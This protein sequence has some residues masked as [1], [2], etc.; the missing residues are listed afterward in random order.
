[1]VV[2][3]RILLTFL[4]CFNV[5]SLAMG[6]PYLIDR[7]EAVI[8]GTEATEIVTKSDF[9]RVA[10]DG[11][12]KSRDDIILERLMFQDAL[13]YHIMIDEKTI[14]EYVEKMQKQ[15]NA[16]LDDIKATFRRSGYTYE[17]GRRQ[18]GI[19]QATNQILDYKIRSK[20]MIPEAQVVD[21]YEKHPQYRPAVYRFERAFI[22]D[23][24]G[25]KKT[26]ER[27]FETFQKTGRGIILSWRA[28]PEIAET[29][30]DVSL[31]FLT[32]LKVNEFSSFRRVQGGHDIFCLKEKQ[33]EEL[34]PLEER[35]RYIVDQLRQPKFESLLAN[36]K[37]NLLED[38]PI[39]YL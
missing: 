38:P 33:A 1:M 17:E 39:V 20:L 28:L 13:R 3:M 21:Y 8:Y 10:L 30:L 29:D 31:Q 27:K 7:V 2:H 15:Y 24:E 32:K 34:V 5:A 12:K 11:T 36:Y 22:P 25:D 14:D 6:K 35:Y 16:T 37:K 26:I 4:F 23:S 9:E 18:L 19:M